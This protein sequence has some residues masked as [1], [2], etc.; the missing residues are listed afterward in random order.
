MI[1]EV[2]ESLASEIDAEIASGGY[3]DI[4]QFIVQ[5][6]EARLHPDRDRQRDGEVEHWLRTEVVATYDAYKA[7]PSRLLSETEAFRILDD[8]AAARAAKA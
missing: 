1:V 2:P 8:L 3:S 5:S 7:D 6:I 4:D